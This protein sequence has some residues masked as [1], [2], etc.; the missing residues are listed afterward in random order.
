MRN[1][2]K[3]L[4]LLNT[5]FLLFYLGPILSVLA[6][7]VLFIDFDICYIGVVEGVGPSVIVVY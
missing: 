7:F 3:F 1:L 2:H 5:V 4:I 6:F